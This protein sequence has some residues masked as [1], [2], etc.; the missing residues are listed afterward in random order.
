MLSWRGYEKG[1]NKWEKMGKKKYRL[2][3]N[4]GFRVKQPRLK[5]SKHCVRKDY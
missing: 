4:L 1:E 3:G 5:R 2:R